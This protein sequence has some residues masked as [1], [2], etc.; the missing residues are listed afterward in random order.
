MLKINQIHNVDCLAGMKDIPDNT[1][2]LTITSPP[3]DGLRTYKGY[4]FEFKSAALELYRITKP[5]GVLV[6]VIGDETI[7]GSESITSSNQKI[8]FKL[9]CG[10]N[11]HDTMIYQKKNFSH[12][13]KSR[14]HQVFEYMFVLSKGKP[15]TFNPLKD[16][17]N[18]TGG[19]I[20]NLGENTFTQK[21]GSKSVRK[22][23]VN[24]EYGMRHNVWLGNTRGQEEMCVKLEHPA[25][26]PKWIVR[27]HI[28]SW[29]NEGDLIFDPMCGS[30]TT[31]QIAK[32]LNR[33]FLGMDISK[34]YC[35]ITEKTLEI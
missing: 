29:S 10:F 25:M 35:Q 11:I 2:D 20:G 27:D 4:E 17:K 3:Y 23:K 9:G 7:N 1:I 8:F 5:G 16:R 31:C 22:K 30:G 24:T 15:K 32:E 21:D 13:E 26:M 6:W 34:E 18:L 28:L 33:N 19:K 14:Y 12:P